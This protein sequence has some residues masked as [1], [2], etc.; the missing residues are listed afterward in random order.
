M[1]ELYCAGQVVK[2]VAGHPAEI[3]NESSSYIQVKHYLTHGTMITICHDR[4]TGKPCV[5]D[6]NKKGCALTKE[7]ATI[8]T[9]GPYAPPVQKTK[10]SVKLFK[11]DIDYIVEEL[12]EAY[13][14]LNR[15]MDDK[16]I[17]VIKEK[18]H[19]RFF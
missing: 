7:K 18:L 9:T 14:E 2:T 3:L 8:P 11:E 13:K 16:L 5:D 12:E 6:A 19:K 4:L 10:P 17:K 1:T 15:S